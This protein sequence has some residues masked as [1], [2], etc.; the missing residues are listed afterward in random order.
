MAK[1]SP[2]TYK[3]INRTAMKP[4]EFHWFPPQPE[5]HRKRP[6]APY[7]M[8]KN[9]AHYSLVMTRTMTTCN[10]KLYEFIEGWNK[11]LRATWSGPALTGTD[12]YECDRKFE[13]IANA[14]R[15]EE[16]NWYN[17]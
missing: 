10:I 7:K 4:Y 17:M 8:T 11:K 9:F 3:I 14:I 15:E 13:E 1:T 6:L 16:R 2:A 5:P 12:R